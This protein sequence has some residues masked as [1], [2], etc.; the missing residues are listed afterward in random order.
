[1]VVHKFFTVIDFLGIRVDAVPMKKSLETEEEEESRHCCAETVPDAAGA[2]IDNLME[3]TEYLITITAITD[4]F[5]ESLPQAHPLKQSHVLP[6]DKVP[7]E[8]I[9]LPSSSV[10]GMT[11]G[12]DG[13]SEVKVVR[14]TID[15][16]TLTWKNPVVHGSNRNQG[17]VVRWAECRLTGQLSTMAHHKTL[18]A[19]RNEVTI[20]GLHPGILYKFCVE[21]VVSV[22][23]TLQQSHNDPDFEK[24][25]R[26]T[27]HVMSKPVFVRTRA[28][29]E[30]PQ[31]WVTGYTTNTCKIHWEKPLLYKVIGK[32]EEGA[33]KYLKLSLE[34]Y[35]LEINGKPHMRLAPTAQSCT[36]IKCK[37]GKTY[38]VV[39]VALTCTEEVKR[40][41]KR[42]VHLRIHVSLAFIIN[43]SFEA[44]L[45]LYLTV[46]LC[47][48]YFKGCDSGHESSFSMTDGANRE[49]ETISDDF[50]NDESPS[51][52]LN[53]T[54][55]KL[56][57]GESCQLF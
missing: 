10:I 50:E 14:T 55:P 8:N 32:D 30:P 49:W 52:P 39:L 4:E 21:A 57:D 35:R 9:W 3:K 15:S 45:I 53:V 25:N 26:R 27:T 33:T 23:T 20:D 38:K 7:P 36:L 44:I 1:M 5:F 24:K 54:V 47:L 51:K 31:P 17:T 29:C 34:G 22:K 2:I 46:C 48:I 40:E 37:P 56:M 19:D 11:S 6:K 13:P 43:F 16:V 28:P 41:R 42:K 18:E 12:T